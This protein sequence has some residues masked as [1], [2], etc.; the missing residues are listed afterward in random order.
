MKNNWKYKIRHRYDNMLS[1]CYNLEDK[2]YK[3]YGARG[4]YVCERW[5]GAEGMLHFYE[6]MGTPPLNKTLDRIN[7]D[8]PYSPENCKWSTAKEQCRNTRRNSIVEINGDK[9]CLVEALEKVG[10]LLSTYKYRVKKGM[11]PEEA[12]TTPVRDKGIRKLTWKDNYEAY[13]KLKNIH[14]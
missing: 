2:K 6:D 9:M 4:I 7:N 11:T 12:L 13:M 10:M 3:N 14:H 8:G 5:L 1:R